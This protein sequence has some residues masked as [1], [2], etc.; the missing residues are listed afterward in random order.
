[1]RR[2]KRS[3]SVHGL[4]RRMEQTVCSRSTDVNPHK[5]HDDFLSGHVQ[6]ECLQEDNGKQLS[7]FL[8]QLCGTAP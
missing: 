7:L 3:L 5:Q 1:M 4:M 6:A 2:E 8:Q